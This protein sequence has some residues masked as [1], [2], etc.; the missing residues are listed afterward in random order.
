M[1][2]VGQLMEMKAVLD[3]YCKTEVAPAFAAQLRRVRRMLM[4]QVRE[5]SDE[6]DNLIREYGDEVPGV[7]ALIRT[8]S[9]NFRVFN[10]KAAP[11]RSVELD[12]EL[13]PQLRLSQFPRISGDDV[14]VLEPVLIIEEEEG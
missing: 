4:D 12:I 6:I 2:T 5:F 10:E 9:P 8:D 7:G 1:Y 11:I 14:D 3:K 13:K